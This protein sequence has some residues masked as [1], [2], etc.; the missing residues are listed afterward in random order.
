MLHLSLTQFY[1][2]LWRP[3]ILKHASVASSQARQ[4]YYLAE[5]LKIRE[6]AYI[7][8]EFSMYLPHAIALRASLAPGTLAFDDRFT[9]CSNREMLCSFPCLLDKAA[10][11]APP[12]RRALA[13]SGCRTHHFQSMQPNRVHCRQL[14][15]LRHFMLGAQDARPEWWT[16]TRPRVYRYARG[17]SSAN[18]CWLTR[19]LTRSEAA[20]AVFPVRVR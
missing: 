7:Y 1:V 16:T 18:S 15:S 3:N 12:Q 14:M 5:N 8:Y 10:V 11:Y 2:Q 19:S 13:I 9:V 4:R 6:G 17:M 20:T